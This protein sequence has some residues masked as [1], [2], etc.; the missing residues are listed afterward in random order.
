MKTI[1][2]PTDFSENALNALYYAMELAKKERARL[3]LL[4]VYHIDPSPPYMDEAYERN[5]T[6]E[7]W[8]SKLKSLQ[9]KVDHAGEI[10][11]ELVARLDLAVDGIVEEAEERNVDLIVMGTHGAS[12][13]QEILMGSNT[14]RV[15]EKAPCPVI[16]VPTGASYQ[17]MKKITFATNYKKIDAEV[18]Q[19]LVKIAD[20]FSAQLNVLHV[21][22][23][24][25]AAA[26]EEMAR[27]IREEGKKITYSNLSYELIRGDDVEKRLEEYLAL[28]T[29]DLMV[30]ST[31]KKNFRD[32]LFGSSITK[33]LVCHSKVPVMAFHYKKK[34]SIMIV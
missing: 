34:E 20:P 18:I 17:H 32:K 28:G 14:T 30:L 8:L 1:L 12:G 13:L 26:K 24:N 23:E 3:I 16:A 22:E 6:E 21:Y 27:F 31:H 4:H 7:R 10:E 29:T 33:K 2:F 5:T 9:T 15:I 11:C 25:E 19:K